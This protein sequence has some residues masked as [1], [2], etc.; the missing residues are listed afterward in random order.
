[1]IVVERRIAAP[2]ATVWQIISPLDDWAQLLPTVDEV[3]RVG[4]PG[5]IREGTAFWLRQP[6][7]PRARWTVTRWRPEAAFVWESAGPGV[8]SVATHQ[9]S[10]DGVGTIL[11]LG[12]DWSG[13]LAGVMRTFLRRKAQR[14]VDQE[15]AAF[16]RLAEGLAS[17]EARS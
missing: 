9:L 14:Y 15:A 5:P 12:L 10:E 7:L 8:R 2:R 11:R 16:A 13:P 6:G 3:T 1:M 4:P 17:D